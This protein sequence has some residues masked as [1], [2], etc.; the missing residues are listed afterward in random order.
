RRA[1][2]RAGRLSHG[3]HTP[4]TRSTAS[5]GAARSR[6][7][8]L[9]LG[10]DGHRAERIGPDSVVSGSLGRRPEGDGPDRRRGVD[11]LQLAPKARERDPAWMAVLDFTDV[12]ECAARLPR[13]G[14][15]AAVEG[16][17]DR[18]RQHVLSEK[19][20]RLRREAVGI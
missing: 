4:L 12:G 10:T 16:A 20:D 18:E 13:T 8:S 19:G 1:A 11:V 5:E 17:V 7:V 3:T 6:R 2:D 9:A 14:D 15:L